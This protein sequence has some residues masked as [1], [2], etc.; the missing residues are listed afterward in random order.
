MKRILA[1]I[2]CDSI[3]VLLSRTLD[4]VAWK[5]TRIVR[6]VEEIQRLKEQ[7]GKD[8]HAVGG[9]TLVSSLMNSGLIDALPLLVNPLVLGEGKAL[10]KDVRTACV[11]TRQSKAAKV[12]QGQ[13]D[14]HHAARIDVKSIKEEALALKRETDCIIGHYFF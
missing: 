5:T 11:E 3:L 7:P 4:K 10:F 6:D 2:P 8:M 14:L 12:G 9:A 1:M 13:P